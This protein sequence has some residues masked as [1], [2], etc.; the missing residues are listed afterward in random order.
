MMSSSLKTRTGATPTASSSNTIVPSSSTS[1]SVDDNEKDDKIRHSQGAQQ[2]R[3]LILF[4][5][6]LSVAAFVLGSKQQHAFDPDITTTTV[7]SSLKNAKKPQQVSIQIDDGAMT[8]TLTESQLEVLVQEQ[9]AKVRA[10]KQKPGMIME[11]DP[12]GMKLTKELQHV[13]HQLLIWTFPR[14]FPTIATLPN[15]GNW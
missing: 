12:V 13:T 7:S 4:V 15:K 10:H 14:A 11:T 9:D 3:H 1:N 6:L 8:T 5:V 2:F